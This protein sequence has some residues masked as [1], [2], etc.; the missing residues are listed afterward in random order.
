M[1]DG[2]F[3]SYINHWSCHQI[4]H[5]IIAQTRAFV[6]LS[7][8]QIHPAEI[9]QTYVC[10]FTRPSS[11]MQG[12]GFKTRL[13]VLW[14]RDYSASHT[15]LLFLTQDFDT[16][17]L[18]QWFTYIHIDIHDY[19]DPS[20]NGVIHIRRYIGGSKFQAA[21]KTSSVTDDYRRCHQSDS[22]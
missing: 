6:E 7:T 20:I 16:R 2:R 8:N 3:D 12:S 1:N 4:R 11:C 21:Y 19:N 18:I 17:L 14:F 9:P 13:L 10:K 5:V 15:A 22:W